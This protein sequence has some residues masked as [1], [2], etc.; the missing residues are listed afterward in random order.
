MERR[1]RRRR[2]IGKVLAWILKMS[3][4]ISAIV[5]QFGKSTEVIDK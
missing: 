1:G 3:S 2:E 4:I 5:Y